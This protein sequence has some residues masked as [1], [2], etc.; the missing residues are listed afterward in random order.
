MFNQTNNPYSSDFFLD[1]L[2]YQAN[3][4]LFAHNFL[5]AETIIETAR[6]DALSQFFNSA[7]S[8]DSDRWEASFQMLVDVLTLSE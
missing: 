6:K 4:V 1:N 3:L 7:L 8:Y 5:N 2:K